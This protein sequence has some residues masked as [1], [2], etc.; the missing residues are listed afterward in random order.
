[1][2]EVL[3]RH[4]NTEP[5]QLRSL[6]IAAPLRTSTVPKLPFGPGVAL[7]TFAATA[8]PLL[9]QAIPLLEKALIG[10]AMQQTLGNKQGA[11]RLLGWGRNTL[12]RKMRELDI[13][14]EYEAD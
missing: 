4:L 2:G 7:P 6:G 12:T 8:P 1:M 10:I 14:D 3:R 9:D 13:Y 11:A 5:P